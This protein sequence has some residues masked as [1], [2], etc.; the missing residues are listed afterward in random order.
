MMS[1]VILHNKHGKLGKRP[2]P[3]ELGQSIKLK[4][5]MAGEPFPYVSPTSS[6]DFSSDVLAW[7]MLGNDDYGDCTFAGRVHMEMGNAWYNKQQ[8]VG[9]TSASVWPTYD[10]TLT[11]YFTY[12]G[13]PQPSNY[14]WSEQNGYDNGA[15]MGQL[16]LWF[17]THDVGPLG[18]IGGFASIDI[19]D[20]QEYQGAFSAFGGLYVGLLVNQEM[21]NET[22]AGE[23]WTST[24]TD[25]IG[26]HCIWHAKRGPTWGTAITWG[27]QQLFSWENWRA[28]RQEAYVVFTRE[29]MEAPGGKFNGVNVAQLKSDLA[30]LGG[31][32]LK[33]AA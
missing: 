32:T 28:T 26:G 29:M 18:P 17:M 27:Q 23:P 31:T 14:T 3:S 30:D 16:L 22:D 25:W 11:S 6:V 7:G 19:T 10:Q 15:D 1:D 4:N 8:A 24:A 12:E 33:A 20:G 9:N 5:Y 21:M 2:V 13:S